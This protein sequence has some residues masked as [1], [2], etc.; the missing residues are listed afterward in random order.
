MRSLPIII[1]TVIARLQR[2]APETFTGDGMRRPSRAHRCR[3]G[4]FERGLRCTNDWHE[5]FASEISSWIVTSTWIRTGG[6]KH[7]GWHDLKRMG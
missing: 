5:N 1:G 2:H 6:A 7:P 3:I 4:C